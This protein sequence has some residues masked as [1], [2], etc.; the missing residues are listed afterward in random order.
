MQDRKE[1]NSLT[2]DPEIS[3]NSNY[4][5]NS[6]SWNFTNYWTVR[7]SLKSLLRSDRRKRQRE[8]K[9]TIS[10][11]L[12]KVIARGWTI[13]VES[14]HKNKHK[15]TI[16]TVGKTQLWSL[17]VGESMWEE[18]LVFFGK[19]VNCST[20]LQHDRKRDWRFIWNLYNGQAAYVRIG[21]G[22]LSARSIGRGVKQGC[23]LSPLLY[24]INDEAMTWMTWHTIW[25]IGKWRSN[26]F[27]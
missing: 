14:K 15:K 13:I 16:N 8:L 11:R 2:A 23:S 12:L 1:W 4:K 10:Y 26:Q 17:I 20:S 9:S 6:T 24:L 22:H 27:N 25:S 5:L 19:L 3:T 21:D 7:N 18:W